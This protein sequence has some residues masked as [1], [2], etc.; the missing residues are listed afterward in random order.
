MSVIEQAPKL[1]WSPQQAAFLEWAKNGAGSCVLIAVAGAGK[2]TVLIEAGQQM[3]GNVA[4]MSFNKDIEVETTAKL[5]KLGVD[6]KT[7]RAGTAHSFAFSA[8]KKVIGAN[9]KV[10]GNKM[11]DIVDSMITE[12]NMRLAPFKSNVVKLVSLA[13]QSIFGIGNSHDKDVGEWLA[14]ADH[15]DIFND[16][17][18]RPPVEEIIGLAQQAMERSNGITEVID[19]DDMIFLALKLKA[20]FWKFNVV[21]VDEAQDTNAARRAL[22]RA[23]LM[24]GGRVVAVGD[25]RQAI[26]MFTGADSDA[27]DLIKRDFNC[28][29]L[30]LTVSYRCPQAVVKFANQW[31][32]HIEAAPTAPEGSVSMTTIEAFLKRND[33]NGEA[34][35]LCRNNAPNVALAFQLIRARIPCRIEGRDVGA[36]IKKLM[37]KWKVTTLNQLEERLAKHFERESTKLL[38]AKKE[39]QLAALEDV[40]ATIKVITDQ[41]RTEKKYNISDAVAYVDHLFGDKVTGMLI[42]SS[43]HKSKGKEW[44]R[45]FWLDRAGT[46]PSK[47]ART[48]EQQ[49]Q[50]I[51]ICYVAATRAKE[52]LIE[53]LVPAKAA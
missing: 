39:Q 51:N 24:K 5:K 27:I 29:E 10:D 17:D 14:L 44:R 6:W 34:A 43:I 45:V 50:E 52:D 37:Q 41:C 12:E 4:Y 40:I 15:H 23:M 47:W 46:C 11:R 22:V 49:I 38:A 36:S 31:V 21:M 28:I 16:D 9:V 26:Y 8:L 53:I 20:P 42:L 48:A 7:M 25:P 19:Y 3:G 2:S 18:Q 13:K 32:K 1:T 30:P 35:V 33:L